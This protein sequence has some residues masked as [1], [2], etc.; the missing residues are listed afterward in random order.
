MK[1][2]ARSATKPRKIEESNRGLPWFIALPDWFKLAGPF[3]F[4]LQA[5]TSVAALHSLTEA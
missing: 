4:Y 2:Y 5:R 3:V 1:S